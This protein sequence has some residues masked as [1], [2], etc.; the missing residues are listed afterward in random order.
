MEILKVTQLKNANLTKLFDGE[1]SSLFEN[2]E[3]YYLLPG[4]CD[5]HVHFRE[6]GFE[7]KETIK[8]GSESAVNGG[9]TTVFTMPNL[10]PVPDSLQNLNLQLE[11]IKECGLIEVIPYGSITKG[12]NGE[13]IS[14]MEENSQPKEK[15]EAIIL[16]NSHGNTTS[17]AEEAKPEAETTKEKS[18]WWK[19][20]IKG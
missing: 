4:F 19:K 14:D 20:L 15:Q 8:S 3:N 18:T 1:Y 17:K 6:P 16:Y 12:Q 11:K 7:Y 13:E 9:Y 2:S 5:V 10:K